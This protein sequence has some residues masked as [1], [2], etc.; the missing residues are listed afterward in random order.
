[1]CKERGK[2]RALAARAE[3]HAFVT[4]AGPECDR[5][6]VEKTY[7]KTG[8]EKGR[9]ESCDPVTIK[10]WLREFKQDISHLSALSPYLQNVIPRTDGVLILTS[11][12]KIPRMKQTK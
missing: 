12:I 1:M 5:N 11:S 4:Y 2:S 3:S 6:S 10:G 8:K 7:P 9:K